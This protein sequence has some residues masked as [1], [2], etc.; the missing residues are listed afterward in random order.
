MHHSYVYFLKLFT[1]TYRLL[2]LSQ[3]Y[4]RI[5]MSSVQHSLDPPMGKSS[6]CGDAMSL[7]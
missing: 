2:Q 4:Q 7:G 6:V 5:D 1:T 3:F